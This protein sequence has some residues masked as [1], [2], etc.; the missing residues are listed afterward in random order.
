MEA[1]LVHASKILLTVVLGGF[2]GV[3]VH[4]YNVLLLKPEKLRS[5]LRRQGIK[6]PSPS[7]ILGNIPQMN[8]IQL[9]NQSVA[10]HGENINLSHDWASTL[11][12][13]FEQWRIEYG[14]VFMYSTGTLQHLCITDLEMLKE[15]NLCTSLELGKPSYLTKE[16]GPLLGQ[17]LLSSS[18]QVWAH[19]RK[20]IAPELYFNKVKRMVNSMVD[21]TTLMLRT[22]ESTI[23]NQG[24]LAVL[25][26]D[27]D[28]RSLSAD[29]ISRCC[30]GSSY[31][32]GK[33]IF[34]MLK[35][36]QKSMSRGSLFVG[37][38]GLRY[39]PSKNNRGIRKLEKEIHLMI[40]KMVKE[41]TEIACEKD[42]MQMILESAKSYDDCDISTEKFIVDNCKT[43]YFAGQE[44]T[45]TSASWAMVLLA[46]YPE[47]QARSRAE[48]LEICGDRLL[49]AN[50]LR[51]MKALT[52]VIHETLRLYPPAP[53][54]L[55][56]AFQDMKFKGIQIP[57]GC[58]IIIPIHILH[59]NPDLWGPDVHQFNPGRFANG[60]HG[61]CNNPLTYVPFGLGNRSC[62]GQ[63]FA[64]TQ[65]KVVLALVLSKFSFSLSA[66]YQHSHGFTSVVEPKH[67]VHLLVK[68]L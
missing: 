8:K 57:K 23:S 67:G 36:L 65:L 45:S 14:S 25:E 12:P 56:E 24:G 62:V 9:Q 31:Y 51:S 48:V 68:N 60:I 6:G 13:Y 27:E 15:I 26:V 63:N 2:I 21:S 33:E 22:W 46:A 39:L 40:L 35:A 19:E 11:F 10:N 42:L 37:V 41:R 64:L 55:R 59:R 3:L 34:S 20:I 52:M 54:V 28:L 5:E 53:F 1:E 38:P 43:L 32:K 7:P 29:I 61:A 17:G 18:G 44:T 30:F 66:A 4:L 58:N 16:R 49:D 50:M 47:W